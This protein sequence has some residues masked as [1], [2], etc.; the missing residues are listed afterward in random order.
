MPLPTS[1]PALRAGVVPLVAAGL[2]VAC[3]PDP[4]PAPTVTGSP[5]PSA[6]PTPSESLLTD[7]IAGHSAVGRLADGFPADLVPVPEGAEVLVSSA[8]P[9][10]DGTLDI[11]LNV[12]TQQDPQ[13]LLEAVRAP[14][15]AAGF[16]EAAPAA[17]EPGLAAQ[18]TF[19]R[20]AGAELLVVGVLDRE[21]TRTMTLGGTV[22]PAIP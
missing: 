7:E 3:G 19:T 20:S 4:S 10:A 21:G 11:S 16:S 1:R 5:A 13:A 17:P 14:L 18:V 8:V 9:G 22:R 6:S 2:L 15:L 12:R